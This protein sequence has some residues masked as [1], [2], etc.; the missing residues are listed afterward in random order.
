VDTPENESF[1]QLRQ[2]QKRLTKTVQQQS[3][4][5]LAAA[6]REARIR[7]AAI[8]AAHSRLPEDAAKALMDL[9]RGRTDLSLDDAL[10]TITSVF[11][12]PR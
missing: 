11:G 8:L 1:R 4:E 6:D 12:D 10:A 2:S 3:R 7:D 5:L 9:A